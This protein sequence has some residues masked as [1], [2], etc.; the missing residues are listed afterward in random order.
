METD[1]SFSYQ[2]NSFDTSFTGT[3]NLEEA[4]GAPIRIQNLNLSCDATQ[5]F[6]QSNK[7]LDVTAI[8][9]SWIS[10][11]NPGIIYGNDAQ[12]IASGYVQGLSPDSA[13]AS[14]FLRFGLPNIVTNAEVS[15]STLV[16]QA[17][18]NNTDLTAALR[19]FPVTESWLEQ[20]ITYSNRPNSDT[21]LVPPTFI[22]PDDLLRTSSGTILPIY[23]TD[24]TQFAQSIKD[25]GFGLELVSFSSHFLASRE[26]G[27]L[28]FPPTINLKLTN[29]ADISISAPFIDVGFV[30]AGDTLEISFGDFF[31][32]LIP[33]FELIDDSLETEDLLTFSL[34]NPCLNNLIISAPILDEVPQDRY[35]DFTPDTPTTIPIDTLTPVYQTN[36]EPKLVYENGDTTLPDIF[37]NYTMELYD[38]PEINNLP[39]AFFGTGTGDNEPPGSGIPTFIRRVFLDDF[40]L[41]SPL[42][43]RADSLT[44]D[45]TFKVRVYGY[46][47]KGLTA[48]KL[49]NGISS[50]ITDLNNLPPGF[51][52]NNEINDPN[53][54]LPIDTIAENVF[55]NCFEFRIGD[56][57]KTNILLGESKYLYAIADPNDETKLLIKEFESERAIPSSLP[58]GGVLDAFSSDDFIEVVS[59]DKSGIYWERKGALISEEGEI[60]TADLPE[61]MIRIIGRFW[62]QQTTYKVKV[63]AT[64]SG[65]KGGLEVAVNAP[66]R[67][68]T[69][70]AKAR[71]VFDNVVNVDSL[72]IANAG[73]Y[74]IPPQ[75]IK[76]HISVEAAKKDFGSDIGNGFAPSYRYEPYTTQHDRY[77][78]Y[79]SGNFFIGDSLSA[80]FSDVPSHSHVLDRDYFK[81]IKT[82]WDV[83]NEESQ[84]ASSSSGLSYGRRDGN[85]KMIYSDRYRTIQNKYNELYEEVS[86]DSTKTLAEI[87]DSTNVLM[88]QYLKYDWKVKYRTEIGAINMIAQ[89]RAA[90]SYGFLQ[91]LYTTARDKVDFDRTDVPEK[92]NEE[93]FFV[94]FIIYQEDLML[95]RIENNESGYEINW[96]EGYE[97]LIRNSIF[98]DWNTAS[99]YPDEVLDR[100]RNYKPIKN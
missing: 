70:F 71:D 92:M 91:M 41:S 90:S 7:T 60:T 97:K 78:E 53:C 28:V 80:D 32:Q 67:L 15:S 87:A 42:L 72:I 3:Q 83:I 74:G 76:A 84:L 95:D 75:F 55:V 63:N 4:M 39:I 93:Q 18:T 46:M 26:V 66:E 73:K 30:E 11:V 14:I 10:R 56:A 37:L 49:V 19:A 81:E 6:F 16:L 96:N 43:A 50:V 85:G 64:S 35:F 33:N 88:I 36:L 8:E 82:V 1:T 77:L 57:Q 23:E 24:I 5:E 34:G 68:G 13:T 89:T 22:T 100:A 61:G 69:E 94:Q 86:L 59:G 27:S 99:S 62:D 45:S 21:T 48:G 79:W 29:N 65:R 38:V 98:E 54:G 51:S 20:S 25:I 52:E 31:N 17:D 12:L 47:V 9:D 58:D 40:T 44:E 2:I